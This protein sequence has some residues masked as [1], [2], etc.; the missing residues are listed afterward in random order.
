MVFVWLQ[1][2]SDQQFGMANGLSCVSVH[3]HWN[4]I[5]QRMLFI[6]L[7]KPLQLVFSM[8]AFIVVACSSDA[9][10]TRR[11]NCLMDSS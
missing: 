10:G 6:S 3:G 11:H 8:L 4:A 7:C 9:L 5:V 1:Y 2:N